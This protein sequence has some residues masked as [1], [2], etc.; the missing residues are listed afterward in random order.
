MKTL[1]DYRPYEFGANKDEINSLIMEQ[2]S[3]C[4]VERLK[5]THDLPFEAFAEPDIEEGEE[6]DENTPT[7]YKEKFQDEYNELYDEEYERIAAEI[8]FDLCEENGIRKRNNGEFGDRIC[9]LTNEIIET[10]KS[11]FL[12]NGQTQIDLSEVEEPTYVIWFDN[13][14]NANE[15]KVMQVKFQ[16]GEISLDVDYENDTITVCED[17]FAMN[18]PTWLNFI[19][20][21][22][23]EALNLSS[24]D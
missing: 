12:A 19:L 16:D 24:D 7:R 6:A 23:R 9:T 21:N 14:G 11:V 8:E 15:G 22:I 5:Q 13:G 10:I 17:D 2:A 1:K 20:E 18:N 4:A 3:D